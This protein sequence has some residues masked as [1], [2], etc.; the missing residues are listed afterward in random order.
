MSRYY[1][2]SVMESPHLSLLDSLLSSFLHPP[3]YRVEEKE[4]SG[5]ASYCDLRAKAKTQY[6]HWMDE[7]WHNSMAVYNGT[8]LAKAFTKYINAIPSTPKN[9][10]PEG[11]ETFSDDGFGDIE[12]RD[13]EKELPWD[14]GTGRVTRSRQA[15]REQEKIEEEEKEKQEVELDEHA[16]LSGFSR[17]RPSHRSSS[18]QTSD[19]SSSH[20]SPSQEVP[21]IEPI[22][23]ENPDTIVDLN[24]VGNPESSAEPSIIEASNAGNPIDFPLAIS[25]TPLLE[26]LKTFTSQIP[27][28]DQPPILEE[29]P[30]LE[31]HSSEATAHMVVEKDA[32]MDLNLNGFSFSLTTSSS[33][34]SFDVHA[35]S[36]KVKAFCDKICL[37]IQP[38]IVLN[39]MDELA[40]LLDPPSLCL[41][42][43][44]SNEEVQELIEIHQ[45]FDTLDFSSLIEHQLWDH[46]EICYQVLALLKPNN[47]GLT[48]QLQHRI[49][50]I[51]TISH[52]FKNCFK[53]KELC[54]RWRRIWRNF[55]FKL[56]QLETHIGKAP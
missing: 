5:F 42:S 37:P 3:F 28:T 38:P 2:A 20:Q 47:S 31:I 34:V 10:A 36:L 26:V 52:I 30:P 25:E 19:V 22:I 39:P 35:F 6:C 1:D 44:F 46:F 24:Q 29:I 14:S 48:R 9:V 18:T 33:T 12:P 56:F 41:K 27:E 51:Q 23:K 53:S 8:S 43:T 50:N 54:R 7:W 11:S 15:I 49:L 4:A 13:E 40:V 45:G 32:T 16:K 21:I 17:N 55:I